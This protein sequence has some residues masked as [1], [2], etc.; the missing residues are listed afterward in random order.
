MSLILQGDEKF[1][2]IK[3]LGIFDFDYKFLFYFLMQK[4]IFNQKVWK[5][6]SDFV[7]YI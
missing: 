7:E 6:L 3:I 5:G 1:F 2:F 4:V